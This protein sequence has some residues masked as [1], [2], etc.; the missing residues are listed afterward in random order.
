MCSSMGQEISVVEQEKL[1]NMMIDMDGTENKCESMQSPMFVKKRKPVCT[2]YL[3]PAMSK[4]VGYTGV[5]CL[6]GSMSS[7]QS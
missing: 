1:D 5:E 3:S 4:K 6:M 2:T 7:G